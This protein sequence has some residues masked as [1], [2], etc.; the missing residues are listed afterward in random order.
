MA[1]LDAA[2][3]HRNVTVR[4]IGYRKTIRRWIWTLVA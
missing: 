2:A 1:A 3:K 4:N